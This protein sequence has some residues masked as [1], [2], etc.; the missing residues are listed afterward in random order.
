M[1]QI[2]CILPYALLQTQLS[3]GCA[4]RNGVLPH[5][6]MTDIRSLYLSLPEIELTSLEMLKISFWHPQSETGRRSEGGQYVLECLLPC[7]CQKS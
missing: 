1:G 4:S 2:T 6:L 3:A 7:P 5:W